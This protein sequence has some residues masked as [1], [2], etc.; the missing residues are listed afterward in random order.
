MPDTATRILA[1]LALALALATGPTAVTAWSEPPVATAEI[2]LLE[3]QGYGI[4]SV[5]RSWLGRIVI[6]ATRDGILREIVI[7]RATGAVLSDRSF[8]TDPQG[9]ATDGNATDR[10]PGGPS[11]SGTAPNRPSGGGRNG[12]SGSGSGSGD[13][14]GRDGGNGGH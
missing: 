8:A 10:T 3:A 4:V 14:S 9:P 13:G 5:R 2:A 1:T 11:S 7:N 12:G 6:L